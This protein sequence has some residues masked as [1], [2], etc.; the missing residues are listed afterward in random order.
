M[1]S[2]AARVTFQESTELAIAICLPTWEGDVRF[3]PDDAIGHL[4]RNRQRSSS[5]PLHSFGPGAGVTWLAPYASPQNDRVT[6]GSGRGGQHLGP[7][8]LSRALFDRSVCLAI[9]AILVVVD[10]VDAAKGR[11]EVRVIAGGAAEVCAQRYQYAGVEYASPPFVR[12]LEVR[13]TLLAT[14]P[15]HVTLPGERS[16]QSHTGPLAVKVDVLRRR[17]G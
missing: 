11:I 13:V 10:T 1:T 17:H 12:V 3:A 9:S 15:S 2:Q 5:V 16:C 7:N 14:S 4:L 8:S 6:F